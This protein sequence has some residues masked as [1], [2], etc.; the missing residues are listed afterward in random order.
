MNSRVNNTICQ[1]TGRIPVIEFENE[2]PCLR[3]L[4][5]ENI[6]SQYKIRMVM[7]KV[8]TAGMITI[9]SN[10]YSVPSEYIGKT[11]KYQ[12]HDSR[13]YVYYGTNLIAVHDIS[14]RKLNYTLEH[15]TDV[16]SFRY[17]GKGSDE[18]SELAKQKLEII[19]GVYK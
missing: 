14:D 19:G 3:P 1:G 18:V 16:L 11:V 10:F 7:S 17:I 9:R 2:R 5:C 4:P 6:R 12:I 13:I 15:Y 8:N